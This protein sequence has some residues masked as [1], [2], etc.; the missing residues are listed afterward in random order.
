[1]KKIMAVLLSITL[2]GCGAKDADMQS[3]MGAYVEN[4]TGTDLSTDNNTVFEG[5]EDYK[6]AEKSENDSDR[7]E[8]VD[9]EKDLE[10]MHAEAVKLYEEG[11]ALVKNCTDKLNAAEEKVKMLSMKDGVLTEEDFSEK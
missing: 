11:T 1:M 7:M 3:P 4:N 10:K 6:K 2:C 9:T 8:A 5:E